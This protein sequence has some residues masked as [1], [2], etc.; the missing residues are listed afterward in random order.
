MA[1]NDIGI[2][3]PIICELYFI[4]LKELYLCDNVKVLEVG[5][6]SWIMGVGLKRDHKGPHKREARRAKKEE[7][8]AMSESG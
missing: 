5:T 1:P 8:S 3:T 6:L 7:G 2:L 4:W